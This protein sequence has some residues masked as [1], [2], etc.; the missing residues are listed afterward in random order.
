VRPFPWLDVYVVPEMI[1][2]RGSGA[3]RGLAGYTNGEVIRNPQR[4]WIPISAARFLRLTVPLGADEDEKHE[5][6]IL[7]IGGQLPTRRIVMT[8]G[9]LAAADIFDTNP[10]R[11]QLRGRSS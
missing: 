11:E 6:D 8:G 7:Q 10:L 5:R 2:G 9:V 3:G 4:E 1:R